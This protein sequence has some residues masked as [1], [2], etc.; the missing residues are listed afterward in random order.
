M[1]SDIQTTEVHSLSNTNSTTCVDK[2]VDNYPNE[3]IDPE[4]QI[5][6]K[7]E[8]ALNVEA[9]K[10]G[11]ATVQLSKIELIMVMIGLSL[12]V[13]LAA[14]DTTIV[15]TALPKIASEFNSLDQ[16]SWVAT[17]YLLTT[18]AL[19]PTYGKFSDIF[20]RKITFLFAITIFEIGSLL[21]GLAPNMVSLIIFRAIAGLGGGGIISLVIVIITDIVSFQDRGKYQGMIGAVFGIASVVG[22]LL[23]GA[24]TD[25]LT[26]RW[27]FYINIPLGAITIVAIIFL[28]RIPRPK[29]SLIQ[30]IKRIDYLGT[31]VMTF[32][33]I[34]F[35]LPLSWG[36]NEYAW[37]S[38]VIIVLLIVGCGGIFL[39]ALVEVKFANEPVSP[40]HLFK[41]VNIVGTFG[42][43][44]FQGMAFFGLI[45]YIPVYFQVIKGDSATASGLELIP[46]IL[47]VVLASIIAGQFMSRTD[48]ASYRTISILG[49]VMIAVGSGLLT[50]WNENTGRGVQIAYMIIAGIGVGVILQ[51]TMLCGQ[52]IVDNKDVAVITSLLSFFRTIGA[53]FGI[54]MIG[55][56]FKNV[57]AHNLDKLSLPADI[58][59]VVRQS[60]LA[61][62]ELPD[63]MRIPVIAAYVNAL[64]SAYMVLVPMGALCALSAMFIGNHKPIISEKETVVVFE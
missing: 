55:T 22:P 48:I 19:Q 5:I 46:Y 1:S 23:G 7:I 37:N 34:A 10:N 3:K 9:L 57:L 16:I 30:K 36:G 14:L 24:F 61:V 26:W 47:G 20:G 50:L 28:L 13:F 33:I 39:F 42:T 32:T 62:H 60:A 18:T 4:A 6:V 40:P 29:G 2:R 52:Q 15:S 58:N 59:L 27:A 64:S 53:V 56:T 43:N 63:D 12:G 17:S 44:F 54:A 49:G 31:I 25:H 21:C 8:D 41:S 51:S 35:L 38:P 11:Q 45:Y